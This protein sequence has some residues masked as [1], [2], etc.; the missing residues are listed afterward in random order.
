MQ[1]KPDWGKG[2]SRKGAA[3]AY[4][5]RDDEAIEAYESGL[6]VDPNNAQLKEGLSEVSVRCFVCVLR[7]SVVRCSDN[8]ALFVS[9]VVISIT[10]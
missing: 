9:S 10:A 7:F 5:G 3:L 2:Y 4:L 8:F 1:L 6:K